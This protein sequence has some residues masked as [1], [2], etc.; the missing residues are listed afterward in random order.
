MALQAISHALSKKKW[1]LEVFLVWVSFRPTKYLVSVFFVKYLQKI[2][3]FGTCATMTHRRDAPL[4]FLCLLDSSLQVNVRGVRVH[5]LGLPKHQECTEPDAV[6]SSHQ[7]EDRSPGAR[8][9]DQVA[10]Q[11]HTDDS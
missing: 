9:F 10:S 11:V 5:P 2:I 8:R 6:D 1:T 3:F 4:S 7:V